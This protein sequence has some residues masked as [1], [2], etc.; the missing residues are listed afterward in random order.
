LFIDKILTELLAENVVE[1]MNMLKL[2][3]KLEQ[4]I[5]NVLWE[6]KTALKPA[7]VQER[8]DGE[9][10]YTTVMTIMQRLHKKGLLKREK[11]GNAFEYTPAVSK[12]EEAKHNLASLYKGLLDAYGPL[13][14]S[15]FMESVQDDPKYRKL[16][17]DFLKENKDD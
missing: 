11:S 14:I 7:E 12:V 2:T 5:M 4:E 17:K 15:H 3:G 16:L 1:F 6:S 8:L 10:A 9:L 13:A